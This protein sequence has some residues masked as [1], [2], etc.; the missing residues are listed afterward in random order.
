MTGLV[1]DLM[2]EQQSLA[3]GRLAWEKYWNS[4]AAYVLPSN[5]KFDSM[6]LNNSGQAMNTVVK[7]PVAADRSPEIFDMTSIWAVERLTA[8]LLSLKTPETER[9]QDLSF[10]TYFDDEHTDEEELA[11]ERLRNY[12]FKVRSN[13]QTGFWDAHRAAAR[14]M[15]GFGDGWMMV[16]EHKAGGVVMP[17]RYEH[18]PL[19]EMY[20]AMDA[21]GNPE[22]NYRV[23][24]MSASQAV[25]RFGYDKVGATIQKSYD[26]P[27]NKHD[28]VTI[29]HCVRPR[30]DN[31]KSSKVGVQASNFASYYIAVDDKHLLGTSGY[32]SFP[33]VRYAWQ[34]SGRQPYSTGPVAYALAEIK[35]L[36]EMSKNELIASQ[37]VLRPAFATYGKNFNRLNLNPGKTNPGMMTQDGKP[38]FAPMNSGVRP[39]FATAIMEQ[40]RNNLREM[41]YLNLWQI[42]IQDQ[43]ETATA[44]LIRAQEKGEMLG[45]VGI[46]FNSGLS[47]L[48]DREL[49]ILD[50]ARAFD[51]GSPLEMPESAQ[52][53]S[54]APVFTS[55]LDRMRRMSEVTG[56]QQLIEFAGLL[57]GGDPSKA[58][59]IMSRFDIDE[60]LDIARDILGAPAKIMTPT[61]QVQA[62]DAQGDQMQQLM[63]ALETMRAGG[64]AAQS[65]GAGSAALAQGAEA[66]A[67]SPALEN[68][69]TEG[70]PAGVNQAAQ[71][72]EAA[73]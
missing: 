59:Q 3:T 68:L 19:N 50:R 36:Q 73:Q 34:N 47:Q 58:A 33:F 39:D 60:M 56:M 43:Q 38:L 29:M 71:S 21:H 67:A 12:L 27:K 72:L 66:A 9:W 53:R 17:F 70:L 31:K 23:F 55:P 63:A 40:R 25:Q 2:D 5:E 8:G 13:P 61:E 57:S 49:G 7:T 44:A 18:M 37:T 32:F 4:I 24:G 14:S 30:D 1:T 35:S 10:E 51:E 42:I 41:L 26:D 28:L 64:E 65:A 69:V 11:A 46:S 45:P 22:K 54:I 48:T 16:H 52:G 20:P 6:L 15:C 62:A